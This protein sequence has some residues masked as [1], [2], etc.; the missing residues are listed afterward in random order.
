MKG[1]ADTNGDALVSVEE[2]YRFVAKE[3]RTYTGNR[4]SPIIKGNYDKKM[5]VGMKYQAN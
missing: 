2:L 4:Q 5:P 3:V 1:E